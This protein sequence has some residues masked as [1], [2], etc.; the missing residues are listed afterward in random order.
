MNQELFEQHF[1]NQF[2][3]FFY[4]KYE[5]FTSRN[6]DVNWKEIIMYYDQKLSAKMNGMGDINKYT[7]NVF[8]YVKRHL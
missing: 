8:Y 1:C 7:K 2:E 3:S 4:E 5:Q 6:A